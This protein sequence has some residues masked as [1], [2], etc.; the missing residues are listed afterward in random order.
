MVAKK[1]LPSCTE[2]ISQLFLI[3]TPKPPKPHPKEEPIEVWEPTE[4]SQHLAN[5]RV[6]DRIVATE[7]NKNKSEGIAYRLGDGMNFNGDRRDKSAQHTEEKAAL[8]AI[9]KT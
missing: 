2:E 9:R 4:W 3:S 1:S 5:T 8:L 7:R 6:T